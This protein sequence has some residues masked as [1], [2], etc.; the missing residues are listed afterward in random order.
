MDVFP[1]RFSNHNTI[2]S[3]EDRNNLC[4]R[5]EFYMIKKQ[6]QNSLFASAPVSL[7]MVQ[8]YSH[9]GQPFEYTPDLPRHPL[10]YAGS[11]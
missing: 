8:I 3:S 6:E 7:I 2:L 9:H 11:G 1:V 10:I 5:Y 4:L